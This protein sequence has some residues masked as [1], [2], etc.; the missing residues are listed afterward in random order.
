MELNYFISGSEIASASQKDKWL[1]TSSS[2]LRSFTSNKSY[3]L[4]GISGDSDFSLF[5]TLDK[6]DSNAGCLFSNLHW[7]SLSGFSINFNNNNELFIHSNYNSTPD[8]YTF[9]DVR[10]AKKNCIGIIKA[11]KQITLL[12]Y[13][14]DS[15]SIYKSQS[16]NFKDTTEISGS[17]FLIGYNSSVLNSISLSGISGV[18]DQL[19]LFNTVLD[20]FDYESILSGFLP[21]QGTFV[22]T[23]TPYYEAK[24]IELK[25]NSIL[26]ES[27]AY[28]IV[29]FLDYIA[30]SAIPLLSGNYISNISGI[31][32]SG[33]SKIYWSGYYGLS[34]NLLCYP[35]GLLTTITGT[36]SPYTPAAFNGNLYF[37][38]DINRSANPTGEIVSS[39]V[40]S[41]YTTNPEIED[42]FSYNRLQKSKSVTTSALVE[43][44]GAE[45]YKKTF[46][47]DGIVSEKVYC[48]LGSYGPTLSYKNIGIE[49]NF[50]IGRYL[51]KLDNKFQNTYNLYW[52]DAR[53]TSADYTISN[54]FIDI[55]NTIETPEYPMVY[56]MTSAN[57]S[58]L[59]T[60]FS[61][62]TGNYPRGTAISLYG[63]DSVRVDYRQ[64][65][66]DFYE[67]SAYH[68]SHGKKDKITLVAL[69]GIYNDTA[70]YWSSSMRPLV[71]Q[72]IVI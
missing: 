30:S 34:Q 13:D 45:N 31:A 46:Y 35:T 36:Y 11:N 68:L 37:N 63:P 50:D 67:T 18:F 69:N 22:T 28:K 17:N 21:L 54:G 57:L 16:F 6:K 48:T 4:T 64:S 24:Q 7:P 2:V 10:L 53:R 33:Q 25:E 23:Y 58:F 71:E 70:N 52:K 40:F 1:D 55:K 56:D 27:D 62:A 66:K 9:S 26:S 8:C 43:S 49:L 44:A 51:F 41:F 65:K 39:H 12:N 59:H 19:V 14:L 38:N 15:K 72:E 61:F 42:F 5:F 29:P 60:S 3:T 20:R 32:N 47:M